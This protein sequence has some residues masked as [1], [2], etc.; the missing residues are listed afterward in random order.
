M[1][2]YVELKIELERKAK[3]DYFILL[4]SVFSSLL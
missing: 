4:K 2:L 3:P 1:T